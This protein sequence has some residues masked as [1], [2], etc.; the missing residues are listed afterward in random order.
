VT[1]PLLAADRPRVQVVALLYAISLVLLG[2]FGFIPGVTTSYG[3]LEVAGDDSGA[4]VLGVF[5]TSVLVN[6]LHIGAGVIGILLSRTWPGARGFLLWGG[7]F[8]VALGALGVVGGADWVPSDSADN[9][10]HVGMGASM[11][12]LAWLYG[13]GGPPEAV[14]T[15]R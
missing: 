12:L 3:D 6:V 10:L 11:L 13:R 4:Q 8:F 7:V 5:Q 15:R 14:T 2:V 1:D 9:W